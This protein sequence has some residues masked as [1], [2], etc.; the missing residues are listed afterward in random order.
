MSSKFT[1]WISV[2]VTFLLIICFLV[3]GCNNTKV[4]TPQ[5]SPGTETTAPKKEGDNDEIIEATHGS[6]WISDNPL[7]FSMMFPDSSSYPYDKDWLIWKAI[8]DNTNVTLNIQA[9]PSSDYAD[10]IK[11]VMSSGETLPDLIAN[12]NSMQ[13]SPFTSTGRVLP[14]SD[15]MDMLPNLQLAIAE[16]NLQAKIE[17]YSE[18]D[19]KLYVLPGYKTYKGSAQQLSIRNDIFIEN[20]IEIPETTEEFY[21]VLKTLK[22]LYPDSYPLSTSEGIGVLN[23]MIT[24][25]GST[26]CFPNNNGFAY[27]TE[28]NEWYFEP[29]SDQYREMLIYVN[30]LMSEG[31]MDP[32]ALTQDSSQ[33][34]QKAYNGQVFVTFHWWSNLGYAADETKKVTNKDAEWRHIQPLQGPTGVRKSR[35][36]SSIMANSGVVIP[37]STAQKPYFEDLL[38]FVD[39]LWYSDEGSALCQWGVEGASYEMVDGEREFIP[40]IDLAKEFGFWATGAY[41]VSRRD[42]A[43]KRMP[44][45]TVE[46]YELSEKEGRIMKSDPNLKFTFEEK[47]QQSLF[48]TPLLDYTQQMTYKFIYGEANIETDWDQFVDECKQK[49]V[50]QVKVLVDQAWERQ[51]K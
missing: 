34:N 48:N 37:A 29:T 9:I 50:D 27:N 19:G 46:N 44:E 28:T 22:Q 40:G 24:W 41:L 5:A 26:G 42:F 47:E 30:R 31:L 33:Y 18:L 3:T 15:Y 51:N 11:V 13:A 12:M 39:I 1:K 17:E 14:I 16:N 20:D 8:K 36:D 35:A 45:S 25:F 23:N 43:F 49:G 7:E 2:F 10:K 21:V 6:L 4:V 32:E 38:K